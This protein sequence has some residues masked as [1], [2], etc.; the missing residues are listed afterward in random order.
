MTAVIKRSILQIGIAAAVSL[1]CQRRRPPQLTGKIPAQLGPI[2]DQ[3]IRPLMA[4]NKIPGMA[5]A[6]TLGGRH[7]RLHLRP[8]LPRERREG[9]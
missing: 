6:V 5:V 8:R 9:P 4:A 7:A 3:V 1:V 2:V